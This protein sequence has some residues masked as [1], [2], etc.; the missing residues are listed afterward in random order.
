[1]PADLAVFFSR[2]QSGNCHPDS[3]QVPFKSVDP[4]QEIECPQQ[5][6]TTT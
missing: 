1:M 5:L 3:T 6:M 4:E 2:R